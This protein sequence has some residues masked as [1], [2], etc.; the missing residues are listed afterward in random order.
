MPEPWHIAAP[1]TPTQWRAYYELRWRILRRPWR[2]ARGSERDELEEHAVH[3]LVSIS[4]GVAL[5]VGRLHCDKDEGVGQIRYMAVTPS[6]QGR[7]IGTL[8]LSYLETQAFERGLTCLRLNA[9]TSAL[10]FYQARGY[11]VTG[12]GHTLYGE[13]KHQRLEKWLKQPRSN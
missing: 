6:H 1:S 12:P 13:I 7:G 2:Q 10:S 3:C 11:T 5:G 4:E 9:R 8:I